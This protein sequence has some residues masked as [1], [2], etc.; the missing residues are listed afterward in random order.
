M[1]R[2]QI[3]SARGA[4]GLRLPRPLLKHGVAFVLAQ[5]LPLRFPVLRLCPLRCRAR[6]LASVESGSGL[7]E[8]RV[9]ALLCCPPRSSRGLTIFQRV[10]HLKA[11]FLADAF[12]LCV[13]K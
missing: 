9:V 11:A 6:R 2:E 5:E 1:Q 12:L 8:R 3:S 4:D 13:T 10:S 7:Q